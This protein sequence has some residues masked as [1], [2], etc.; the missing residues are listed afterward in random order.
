M[1]EH[2]SEGKSSDDRLLDGRVILRQPA[3]GFRAAIDPV[4]L[5]AAVPAV[6][7]DRVLELG[8]G[9]GAAS[10]CLAWRVPGVSIVGL[11]LQPELVALATANAAANGLD[12]SVTFIEGDLLRPPANLGT[13]AFD[14]VMANPPYLAPGTATLPADAA[15]AAAVGEGE[16]Q[17]ADW[18]AFALSR[19]RAKGSVTFIHRADR[20]AALLAS[21][22][23]IAGDIAI[24]PL[25]PGAEKPAKR[26][27]VRARRGVGNPSRLL[28]GLVL[29][30]PGGAFTEA[31]EAILREG[32]ALEL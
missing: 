13:G 3:H 11:E 20:L 22:H 1:S 7:G 6:A 15:R 28:P 17:L 21:L 19:V 14:H 4:L 12:A 29:H 32:D 5:A 26:V 18:I 30:E 27:L 16:A 25:W 2:P 9:T 10:L 8:A 31:A 24:L 23:G